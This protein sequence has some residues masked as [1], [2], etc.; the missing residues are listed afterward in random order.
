MEEGWVKLYRCLLDKPIWQCST[1]A[2]KV[3]L[4]TLLLMVNH[5]GHEWEW[6][7][8]KF[9]AQPGQLVTSLKS[10]A[11]RAGKGITVRMV[12]VAME[13]FREYGFLT[14]ESSPTGRLITITNWQIYQQPDGKA[15]TSTKPNSDADEKSAGS[16]E[17]ANRGQT[18]AQVRYETGHKKGIAQGKAAV[19]E[20]AE[21]T[22]LC[23]VAEL[24]EGKA[25]GRPR[26]NRGQSSGQNRATNKNDINKN[27][28]KRD[29]DTCSKEQEA[30]P[31][32][33]HPSLPTNAQLIA[34]LVAKYRD[35]VPPEKH[36]RGDY[37]FV[38]KLY[39][40]YG[41]AAVL[42]ELRELEYKRD[43]GFIPEEPLVYL[44]AMLAHG[45]EGKRDR[46]GRG[47]KKR[48]RTP[49][50]E[51]YSVEA[52][53]RAGLDR[54]PRPEDYSPEAYIRAGLH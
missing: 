16:Q 15:A 37:A 35:I 46:P 36:K 20:D 13:R 21:L 32:E 4:I 43:M 52:F 5:K 11:D 10:I 3:I 38:G 1:A 34:E 39:N 31:L 29:I 7:G 30:S 19:L 9:E 41:Y 27:D 14:W 51:D 49:R 26:A 40:D 28:K 54:G 12:R 33:A 45:V 53:L 18:L 24:D 8:K 6:R 42:E 23:E 2:Q 48:G 50:P 25:E 22:R 44:K 17:G 47:A